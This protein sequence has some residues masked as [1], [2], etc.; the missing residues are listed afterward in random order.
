[1]ESG[2]HSER[3]FDLDRLFA[4]RAQL[5]PFVSGLARQLAAHHPAIICGPVT[6]GAILAEA[7]AAELGLPSIR[8][9]RHAPPAATELFS[10]RYTVPADQRDRMRGRNVAIVDDAISA[11]SA[12]RGKIAD[13]LAGDGVPIACGALFVFGRTIDAYAAERGLPVETIARL[14]FGIWPPDRCP[15]CRDALPLEHVAA[16]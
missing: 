5:Q 7:I 6:G 9:D 3:W 13:V 1:M 4:D 15:L 14:E 10:V 12:V 8:A 16:T 11:G 2:Y